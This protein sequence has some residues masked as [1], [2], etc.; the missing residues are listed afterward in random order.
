MKKI[1]RPFIAVLGLGLFTAFSLAQ[2]S[3]PSLSQFLPGDTGFK[4]STGNQTAPALAAGGNTVL[5]AWADGRAYQTNFVFSEFETSR[6]IYAMRFDATGNPLD[7]VPFVVTQKQAAQDLPQ[8]AWN[9]TAWLVA[10]ES[11]DIGGTGYYEKSLEAVRI[12]P[13]GQVLDPQPIKIR[14]VAPYGGSWAIASDGTDW[15]VAFQS[16]NSSSALSVLRVTAAGAVIQG[17]KLLV[18]ST[19]F[20][21]FNLKLAYAAGVYLFTWTEFDAT[22]AIRFDAGLNLLDPAPFLLMNAGYAGIASSGS[23]FYIVWVRQNPPNYVIEVVGSRV[24]TTGAILDGGGLGVPISGNNSPLTDWATSVAWD[25]TNFRVSWGFNNGV[26]VARVDSTGAVLDP[27]GASVPGPRSGPTAATPGGNLQIGWSEL[28]SNNA[29]YDVWAANISPGFISGPK[30]AA[31]GGAPSQTRDDVAIGTDG[32]MIVFRSDFSNTFR[33]MVQPLDAAGNV[34]TPEPILLDT[35][36]ATTGPGAPSIAWNGSVYLATWGSSMGIRAQRINQNGS[37]VDSS[38]FAVMPGFGPTDVSATGTTFLVIARQFLFGNPEYIGPFVAR[39]DGVT[40]IS[41]DPAGRSVGRSYCVSV[42]VTTVGNRWLAAFRSNST[43]D[44]PAGRTYGTFVDA[45]GTVGSEFSIYGPNTVGG[46]GH[47]EIAAASDGTNAFVLQSN[48]VSSGAET[49]LV[50]V[51]VNPD[52]STRLPVNLTPWLG[53]QYSERVAWDGT[54]YVVVYSDQRTRFALSTL[55]QLDAR[56]D[57]MGMRVDAN[58]TKIDPFGFVVS[59]SAAAE[60]YANIA[61]ADGVTLV[62]SAIMRNAPFNAY[63]IGFDYLG[64]GGNEWP[65]A[66]A[67]SD[68]SAGD[69]PLAV[70]FSSTGTM[71][72]DG[73]VFSYLWNFGDG[74]TSTAFNPSHTYNTPGQYVVTLQ[75]TDNLGTL[76]TA[77]VP[78]EATAP[79]LNPVAMAFATPATGA[80]P[81]SVVFTSDGSYD[82]D[83]AIGNRYWAFS[84]GNDYWGATAYN[85]FAAPGTY[86]ATLTVYDHRGGTGTTVI[87]VVAANPNNVPPLAPSNLTYWS[88]F[89]TSADIHWTDNSPNESGFILERCTGTSAFCVANP[90][91]WTPTTTTGANVTSFTQTGLA[92]NTTYSWRVKAFN[93]IGSSSYS[94]VLT[95]TTLALPAAPT[96]LK[97]Q[98][99]PG[100]TKASVK[101]QWTDNATNETG[102]QVER[103]KGATCTNFT[104]IAYLPP[105]YSSYTNSGLPH[106]ATFRYRVTANGNGG[107]S[108]YS[109]IVKVTTQ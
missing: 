65:V 58:G 33:I 80:A 103:C 95:L 53:N 42:S 9:G 47:L 64:E 102:Y 83:G 2:S 34:L 73:S 25:G 105:N 48:E 50:G 43:H 27:G 26:S 66:A 109:N 84:D 15:V 39:V 12:A 29:E 99:K 101:L 77:T 57:I 54:H 92:Q 62:T 21:R 61:S 56:S 41:L 20:L 5:M 108:P 107:N 98:A 13:S 32:S 93:A 44:N 82:P 17:P 8:V 63:R 38:P 35:G 70:S 87:T 24:S 55:D 60:G 46:N 74:S 19:Y 67:M 106:A 91:S 88:V 52:S 31:G 36:N 81:L 4:P 79:N 68:V 30:I 23:Q 59:A 18:P 3:A 71:D 7:A 89:A 11:Y 51:I 22:W 90:G 86:T 75:V 85:T 16:S 104:A 94:N 69:T 10:F 72:L 76:S 97:A 40:G 6:D 100:G 96:N 37:L 1:V 49:D 28:T 45:N 78:I 14:N